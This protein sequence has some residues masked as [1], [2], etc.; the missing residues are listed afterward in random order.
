MIGAIKKKYLF[1]LVTYLLG[2]GGGGG[3][4]IHPLTP[5]TQTKEIEAGTVTKLMSS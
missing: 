1:N 2:G 3:V 5:W 4:A